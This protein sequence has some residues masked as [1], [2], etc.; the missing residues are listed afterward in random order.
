MDSSFLTWVNVG[1]GLYTTIC[2]IKMLIQFGLSNHPARYT[3]LLISLCV[4]CYFVGQ[5]LTDL[6][7]VTPFH[8]MQWRAIPLV[9]GSLALLLQIILMG[10]QFGKVQQKVVSRLPIIAS[11][12]VFAFFSQK[13]DYFLIACLAAGTLFLSISV[14]KM[15]YQKR[16]FIKMVFILSVAYG[17][18]LLNIYSIYILGE[19]LMFLA[20]FY[21][22]IFENS[23]GVA[24]L[25]DDFKASLEGES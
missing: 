11:L 13:A 15:R 14:G 10:S 3:A 4:C 12:L 21:F 17:C 7:V 25:V 24:A 6:A 2:F 20:V 19:L 9:A 16:Q 5:A 18:K 1:L 8:W 23:I 22:F